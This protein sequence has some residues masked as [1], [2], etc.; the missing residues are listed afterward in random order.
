MEAAT[1]LVTP[2][3]DL[4][5]AIGNGLAS[6]LTAASGSREP[7]SDR[8]DVLLPVLRRMQL[9]DQTSG[10]CLFDYV[11]PSGWAT[12]TPVG[13][14]T[15]LVQSL[16]QFGRDVGGGDISRVLFGGTESA[17]GMELLVARNGRLL[18]ALFR[19]Y[20]EEPVVWATLLSLRR[21]SSRR[22]HLPLPPAAAC[23]NPPSPVY[24]RI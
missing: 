12:D 1:G 14:I 5:D 6:P 13:G 18:C 17:A 16:H 15:D 4:P 9:I 23:R 2:H 22:L 20:H 3:E 21:W 7:L 8:A 24:R 11:W 19:D 10:V